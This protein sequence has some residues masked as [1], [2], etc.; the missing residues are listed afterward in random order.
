MG[1]G[2]DMSQSQRTR[3]VSRGQVMPDW[4]GAT[5]VERK[6]GGAHNII[7]GV[8]GDDPNKTGESNLLGNPECLCSKAPSSSGREG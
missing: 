6:L 3:H 8:E 2:S 5:V 4:L 7:S 1:I